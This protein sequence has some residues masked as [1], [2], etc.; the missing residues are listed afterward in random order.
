MS[1]APTQRIMVLPIPQSILPHPHRRCTLKRQDQCH[2]SPVALEKAQTIDR[3]QAYPF[4][5]RLIYGRGIINVW[6]TFMCRASSLGLAAMS[7]STLT[8]YFRAMKLG[9]SCALTVLLLL[10]AVTLISFSP[11]IASISLQSSK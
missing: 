7:D 4:K 5:S 11:G 8:P 2:T 1:R 3:F 6:P 9:V 10:K